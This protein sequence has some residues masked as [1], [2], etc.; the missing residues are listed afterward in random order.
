MGPLAGHL[1]HCGQQVFRRG[2]LDDEAGG[3]G[4]DEADGVL[5]VGVHGEDQD[6]GPG[7]QGN[8]PGSGLE[9]VN[10]RQAVVQNDHIGLQLLAQLHRFTARAG[11]PHH[12]DV[13]LAVQ[14][15]AET[16]A[17]Q[18][19]IVHHQ[20]SNH[21]FFSFFQQNTPINSQVSLGL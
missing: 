2:P 11:F 20:D 9:A 7:L 10:V 17:Y 12:L 13:I 4:P 14:K 15:T 1:A 16:C 5:L 18:R 21:G 19:V 8:D 6:P 3:P